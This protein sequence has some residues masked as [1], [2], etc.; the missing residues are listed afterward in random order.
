VFVGIGAAN[1]LVQIGES[2][3]E[4]LMEVLEKSDNFQVRGLAAGVLGENNDSRAITPLI[5][6]LEDEAENVRFAS[7]RGLIHMIAMGNKDVIIEWGVVAIDPITEAFDNG[8]IEARVAIIELTEEYVEDKEEIL[9]F[10]RSDDDG[11]NRMGVS[12]LKGIL[13]E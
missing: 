11:L 13:S 5:E 10:L 9:K 12:L 8:N 3:I 2:A 1:A 4:P 6:A 7:N